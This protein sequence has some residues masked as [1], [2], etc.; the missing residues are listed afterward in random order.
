MVPSYRDNIT[1]KSGAIYRHK[2]DRLECD[3]KHIREFAGTFGE[4][5][6][7]SLRAPS[8]IYDHANTK[9]HHTRVDD[10]SIVGREVHKITTT[11]KK[12]MYARVNDVAL[13]KNSGKFQLSYIWD[14]ILLNTLTSTSSSIQDNK[15][16]DMIR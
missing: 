12:V 4:R 7:E 8:P 9:D 10:F 16:F 15:E 1:Q 11:F 6:Q 3:E 13:N 2:C 5:F 14:E